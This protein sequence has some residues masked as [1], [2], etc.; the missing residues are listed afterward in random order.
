MGNCSS[1]RIHC[2][3]D[4]KR[5]PY[6]SGSSTR[7]MQLIDSLKHTSPALPH[8]VS[9]LCVMY[10]RE[11]SNPCIR[12]RWNL[13]TQTTTRPQERD[14]LPRKWSECSCVTNIKCCIP[15]CTE[16]IGCRDALHDNSPPATTICNS[17]FPSHFQS[18]TSPL[19]CL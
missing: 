7:T 1:T 15:E 12:D 13:F 3:D 16:L 19:N 2:V 18:P 6:P 8:Y 9:V 5:E 4:D 14:I 11:P 10:V 17:T